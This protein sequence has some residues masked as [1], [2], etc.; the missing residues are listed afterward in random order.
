MRLILQRRLSSML[1]EGMILKFNWSLSVG[2][3]GAAGCT[4]SLFI[5]SFYLSV[6]CCPLVANLGRNRSEGKRRRFSCFYN[7]P[8]AVRWYDHSLIYPPPLTPCQPSWTM[9]VEGSLKTFSKNVGLPFISFEYSSHNSSH[10]VLRVNF[11]TSQLIVTSTGEYEKMVECV[12]VSDIF[13]DPLC[14]DNASMLPPSGW[15]PNSSF[16]SQRRVKDIVLHNPVRSPEEVA[17]LQSILP[18]I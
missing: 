6:P 17:L 16:K 12:T 8:T 13:L 4:R 2:G 10:N 5:Q 7:E 1:K 18:P 11:L 14:V 3:S 9:T 15:T